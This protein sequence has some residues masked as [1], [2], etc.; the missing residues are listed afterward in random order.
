MWCDLSV[1]T[2]WLQENL[3]SE[4][5]PVLET[6][7]GSGDIAVGVNS[8]GHFR[9]TS[10]EHPCF[11]SGALEFIYSTC[12]LAIY[13]IAFMSANGAALMLIIKTKNKIIKKKKLP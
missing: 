13:M 2:C 1:A 4:S 5:R 10:W 11:L 8:N 6:P 3:A 12:G 9:S 7:Y